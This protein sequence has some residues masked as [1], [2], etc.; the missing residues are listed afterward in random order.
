MIGK[1]RFS[2]IFFTFFPDFT[3]CYLILSSVLSRLSLLLQHPCRVYI[4]SDFMIKIKIFLDRFWPNSAIDHALLRGLNTHFG[5]ISRSAAACIRPL[6]SHCT[7]C[8][9]P[10]HGLYTA[11]MRL[12]HGMHTVSGISPI[13]DLCTVYIR[14]PYGHYHPISALRLPNKIFS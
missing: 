1:F 9:R 3:L 6:L 11:T 14:P 13:Y 10:V 2:P 4:Q 7:A 5:E 8:I 12:L